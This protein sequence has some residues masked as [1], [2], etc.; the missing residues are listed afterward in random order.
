MSG[1]SGQD[2]AGFVGGLFIEFAGVDAAGF[3]LV[4][5]VPGDDELLFE[6]ALVVDFQHVF[7]AVAA[8]REF[9][10]FDVD[11]VAAH[12]R[13]ESLQLGLPGAQVPEVHDLVP[14]GGGEQVRR[15]GVELER[16]HSVPV[17]RSLSR[18]RPQHYLLAFLQLIEY[19]DRGVLAPG[20]ERVP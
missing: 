2:E 19:R 14:A 13:P 20:R 9:V 16:E 11:R 10:R 5:V 15:F 4:G 8:D 12:V 1:A 3:V 6:L 17:A 7:C 18:A